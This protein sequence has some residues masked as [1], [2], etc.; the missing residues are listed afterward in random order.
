MGPEPP[1]EEE[2]PRRPRRGTGSRAWTARRAR[3]RWRRRSAALDGVRAAEVSFGNA[4]LAWRRRRAP[5]VAGGRRARRLPGRAARRAAPRAARAVLA[6]RPARGLDARC[7]SRCWRSPSSPT[8]PARRARSPSR[9]TCL[10]GRRRLA[11]RARGAGGAATPVAGHERADDA[12][13]RRRRRHR[14]LRRGRVGARAVRA[15]HHARDV[16]VRPQPPFGERADGARAR[17]ARIVGERRRRAARARRGGA[18]GTRFVVRPGERVPLDGVVARG[19]S[20]VD[21]APITG[22][23]V[24]VD[25]QPGATVF[26]GTLNA[27][28][29]LTV[30]ATKAARGL[31]A[32]ADRRAGRG[33]A[34]LAG[35]VGALRRPLRAHLH[36]AGVRG[37][38][39]AGRR[40]R[41]A[42]RR[43]ATRGST[44]AGAAD[45]RLPVLARDLDPGRGRLGGRARRARGRADQ[46]RAGARGPR[47]RD[48]RR[49]R[50]DRHAD[51]RASRGSPTSS[52]SGGSG[53]DEALRAGR[54]RRAPLRAS[55]RRAIVRAARERGPGGRRARRDFAGAARPRRHRHGRRAGAAGP[56]ARAWPPSALGALP[57]AV[58]RARGARPDRHRARRG[59]PRARRLR[60]RRPAAPRGRAARSRRC[61]PPASSAIVMLTGD[62]ERVAAAVAAQVGADEYRASCCPRTSSRAVEELDAPARPGGDGRRRHQRR[63]RRW[64]RR[65]SASPWA[66]PAAT[67]RSRPPTSR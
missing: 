46:G 38:A 61:A 21:E 32:R 66:P 30:R 58:A 35:A 18:V 11:D 56:A 25:K 36:A 45:R 51:P 62:N 3:G 29:A 6:P 17:E 50:Q 67:S 59:R 16:R 26:A 14:R 48:G 24:P 9:C 63:A 39:R 10:D 7:R 31:D 47:A 44:G 40:P 54:R 52:R 19:R 43:A 13:R 37:R 5:R 22:E 41:R 53:E 28:G 57:A 8:W 55:A 12:G 34:G 42:R 33:G 65:T 64:R 4:T 49:D 20:G 27:Q 15:R 60:A 2:P 1:A 23:S